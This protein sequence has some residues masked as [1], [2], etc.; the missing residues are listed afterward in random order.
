M[1]FLKLC[2]ETKKIQCCTL[3]G[4]SPVPLGPPPPK[5]ERLHLLVFQGGSAAAAAAANPA[6]AA[7]TTTS[8]DSRYSMRLFPEVMEKDAEAAPATG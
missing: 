6:T 2:G 3:K 4:A 5:P 1:H 7:T 8:S